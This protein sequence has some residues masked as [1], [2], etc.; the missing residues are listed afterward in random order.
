[1]VGDGVSRRAI[2]LRVGVALLTLS[3]LVP[4]SAIAA[5]H[6]HHIAV[7]AG[8]ATE[9]K[10]PREDVNGFALGLEYE[11]RFHPNWG[12]G[13]AVEGLPTHTFPGVFEKPPSAA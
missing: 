5:D 9:S 7:F 12:I 6:P 10:P 13:G 11:Y 3:V 8:Y 4:T 1:M 2:A